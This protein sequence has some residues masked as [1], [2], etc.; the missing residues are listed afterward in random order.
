MQ[1]IN[2]H[3]ITIRTED[4]APLSYAPG[5]EIHRLIMSMIGGHRGQLEKDRERE[6]QDMLNN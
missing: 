2:Y 3:I 5:M 4:N 1:R 6:K